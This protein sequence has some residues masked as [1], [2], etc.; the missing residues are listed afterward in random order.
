MEP[1]DFAAVLR[2]EGFAEAIP[3][4][5]AAGEATPLHTHDFDA[6]VL[7]TAG[8]FTLCRDGIATTHGPGGM[9]SVPRGHPHA[10]AAGPAGAEY[11]AGRRAAA[12]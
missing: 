3:R 8:A 10:E 7:V 2:A 5:L 9:F 4:S 1:Q 12:A 11:L 6:K